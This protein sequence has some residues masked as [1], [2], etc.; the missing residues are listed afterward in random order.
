VTFKKIKREKHILS[1]YYDLDLTV[2]E[3]WAFLLVVLERWEPMCIPIS[4]L[5]KDLY[6]TILKKLFFAQTTVT[7][8]IRRFNFH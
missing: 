6:E 7:L 3:W 8:N 5:L 1:Q 4:I 2:V